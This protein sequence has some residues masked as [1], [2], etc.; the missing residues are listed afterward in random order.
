MFGLGLGLLTESN[1]SLNMECQ[2][3]LSSGAQEAQSMLFNLRR[4]F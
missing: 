3:N 4:P 1:F 2:Y